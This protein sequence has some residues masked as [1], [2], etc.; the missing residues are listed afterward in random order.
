M[1]DNVVIYSRVST[2]EQA[3]SGLS[4]DIQEEKCR[5]YADLHGLTVV[6]VIRD[7]GVSAKD[8]NRPGM[9]TL[10]STI[11]EGAVNGIVVYRL[12]R[13]T[14]SVGDFAAVLHPELERYDVRLHGVNDRIDTST[15]TGRMQ[16]NMILTVA[17]WERETTAERIRDTI[18]GVRQQGY[19]MGQAPWGWRCIEHDGP[20][21]LLAT[22]DAAQATIR[23]ARELYG[24]GLSLRAIGAEIEVPHPQ[25]VKRIIASPVAE[26][27]VPEGNGFAWPAR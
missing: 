5:Q 24:K 3:A 17:Q 13:L 1:S 16:V 27:M 18:A 26:D 14:R 4:L 12:D 22:N 6:G 19:H 9:R 23:R 7:E 25:S 11:K 21:S 10:R 2:A 8:L 15:A 20:G